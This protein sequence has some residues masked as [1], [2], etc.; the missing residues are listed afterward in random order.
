MRI[1]NGVYTLGIVLIVLGFA[2][3]FSAQKQR[4][5]YVNPIWE[6]LV[7]CWDQPILLFICPI[8]YFV[9]ILTGKTLP[10]FC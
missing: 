3:E 5:D 1:T 7:I 8:V 2:V 4:L 10:G 9:Y 6:I